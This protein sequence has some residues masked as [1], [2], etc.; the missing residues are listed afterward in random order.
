MSWISLVASGLTLRM[1]ACTISSRGI[2]DRTILDRAWGG[3][4]SGRQ[5]KAPC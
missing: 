3:E 5:K 2:V 1:E 4:H